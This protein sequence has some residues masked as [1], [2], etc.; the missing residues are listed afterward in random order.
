MMPFKQILEDLRRLS[1]QQLGHNRKHRSQQARGKA[2]KVSHQA[3]GVVDKP[4]EANR[5]DQRAR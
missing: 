4:G 1:R 2:N 3:V 5:V